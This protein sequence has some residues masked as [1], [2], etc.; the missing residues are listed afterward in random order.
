MRLSPDGKYL[1]TS[2]HDRTT[3]YWETATGRELRSAPRLA[4][5]LEFMADGTSV[6]LAR[7]EWL[8]NA[9]RASG[10]V[11]R[12]NVQTGEEKLLA[13]LPQWHVTDLALFDLET[14]PA[15]QR[16]VAGQHPEV[17]RRLQGH[18]EKLKAGLARTG[19]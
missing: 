13:E 11:W 7:P 2:S 8:N 6:I 19:N 15:E 10:F 4:V 14:D 17:V 18:A 3:R 12:W 1:V 5:A 9:R 16:N